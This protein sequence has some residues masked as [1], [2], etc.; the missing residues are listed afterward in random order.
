MFLLLIA[1]VSLTLWY[2]RDPDPNFTAML[3]LARK[4]PVPEAYVNASCGYISDRASKDECST[5]VKTRY[6]KNLDKSFNQSIY[7]IIPHEIPDEDCALMS[8]ALKDQGVKNDGYIYENYFG[9]LNCDFSRYGLRHVE[10]NDP[11]GLFV[12]S[13]PFGLDRVGSKDEYELSIRDV[14]VSR[15]S[16]NLLKSKAYIEHG[17]DREGWGGMA[18]FYE[19]IEGEWK[20]SGDC[21]MTWVS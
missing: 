9:Q 21:L 13:P 20:K 4:T 18:C 1:A 10:H 6:L 8:L 11:S 14:Y 7:L 19:R 15:P 3:K 12:I 5:Q 17:R 16:Y 2:N